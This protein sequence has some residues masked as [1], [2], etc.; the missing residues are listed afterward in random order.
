MGTPGS[1]SRGANTYGYPAGSVP[2][3]VTGVPAVFTATVTGQPGAVNVKVPARQAPRPTGGVSY[4]S[5]NFPFGNLGPNILRRQRFAQTKQTGVGT[6]QPTAKQTKQMGTGPNKQFKQT[7]VGTNQPTAVQRKQAG[8]GVSTSIEFKPEIKIQLGN[9]AQASQKAKNDPTQVANLLKLVASLKNKLPNNSKTKEVVTEVG[10]AATNGRPLSSTEVREAQRKSYRTMDLTELYSLARTAKTNTN[11]AEIEREIRTRISNELN[12]INRGSSYERGWRLGRLYRSLPENSEYRRR[13]E[14]S[15]QDEFRRAGRSGNSVN[16]GRRLKDLMANFGF[17]KESQLPRPLREEYRRQSE[18]AYR[19]YKN[20]QRRYGGGSKLTEST[21]RNSWTRN[22]GGGYRPSGTP[23][24]IPNMRLRQTGGPAQGPRPNNGL[25]NLGSKL[26]NVTLKEEP[27]LPQNQQTAINRAGG[28]TTALQTIA[29]VPGGAPAVAKAAADLNEM[30]GNR[31]K[32][33]ELKGTDPV[34]MNAVTKLG[35]PTNAGYALE[36]LNTLSR[37][38][39]LRHVAK[40]H[41]RKHKIKKGLRLNELNLV[42]NAVK[43]S[44]LMGL[45]SRKVTHGPKNKGNAERK[46]KYY[47]RVIKANIL[48]TPFSEIVRQAAK[49][50]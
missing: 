18:R 31:Q 27:V 9:L 30:G 16:S 22:T 14:R 29:Q 50:N 7:G 37:K 48:R 43:K 34:A 17:K 46:K 24:P 45:V 41:A 2:P 10:R 26:P 33:M 8:G 35:G 15:M 47:K 42:I 20:E 5:Q 25:G 6:N 39:P 40:K 38:T 23:G 44:R 11:K 21:L 12:R 19:N 49:K 4:N 36:G 13:I 32:A 3:P 1:T 28:V